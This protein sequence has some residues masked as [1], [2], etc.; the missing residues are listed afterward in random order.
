[1]RK[2]IASWLI[3]LAELILLDKKL[4]RLLVF[5]GNKLDPES[6]NFP[7]VGI[8]ASSTPVLIRNRHSRR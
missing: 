1:M 2:K 4:P 6:D 5:L 7:N 3:K 8:K